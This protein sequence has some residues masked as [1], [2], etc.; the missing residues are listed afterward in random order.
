MILCSCCRKQNRCINIAASF[1]YNSIGNW[2]SCWTVPSEDSTRLDFCRLRWEYTL[3]PGQA[4]PLSGQTLPTNFLCDSF[5]AKLSQGYPSWGT[6]IECRVVYI[7]L[8]SRISK[9]WYNYED[10][11]VWIKRTKSNC[12]LNT[13]PG[14]KFK[15]I[16]F[17]WCSDACGWVKLNIS[18]G[19]IRRRNIQ[20]LLKYHHQ[21]RFVVVVSAVL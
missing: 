18:F 2:V 12:P 1:D 4:Q 3:F 5:R 21:H 17:M 6:A 10:L 11:F 16:W 19:Q 7:T 8:I 9:I 20:M 13:L 15:F 14:F